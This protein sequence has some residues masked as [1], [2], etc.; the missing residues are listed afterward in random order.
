MGQMA[1]LMIGVYVNL[2]IQLLIITGT[3]VVECYYRQ[4]ILDLIKFSDN[5]FKQGI[6]FKLLRILNKI[7]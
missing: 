6:Y 1:V 7:F 3:I 5:F 4:R 2:I